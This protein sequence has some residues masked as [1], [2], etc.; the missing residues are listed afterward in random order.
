MRRI[1]LYLSLALLSIPAQGITITVEPGDQIADS[2]LSL[3]QGD[4]LFLMPG[5]YIDTT[6]QPL[7]TAGPVQ[8]GVTITSM[9]DNRAVLD[10]QGI[11]RSVINLT[12]PHDL[13]VI[14]ENLII[15]GGNATGSEA[16]NG[17]GISASESKAIIS[18]CLVTENTA[19]IGGGIGAEG[20]ILQIQY[21]T[22]SDNEA[23]VTGGGID[24]YACDFTGFMV[25]FLSNTSS[26][27]GGGINAYQ[28][29]L[30][31]SNSLF[32]GNCSGDDGGAIAV[33][34][35][36]S[37]FSFLTIHSNEAFDDGGGIRIHTVDSIS[38]TS[39]IVTSNLGKAGINVI[40]VNIPFISHVCCWDNTFSNYNG[41][42]DPTGTNGNISEDPLFADTDLNIS[43][44]AAGQ[45][46]DSPALNSGHA[47]VENTCIAGFSTRT[48]SLP[49]TGISDMGFHHINYEQTGISPE[50]PAER[51]GMTL[52]PS[53]AT[54]NVKVTVSP[55]ISAPV[56]IHV[57]D[58]T[59]RRIHTADSVNMTEKN[60]WI[61]NPDDSFPGGLV[62]FR[63]VWSDGSASG[64]VVL[65]R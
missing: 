23:L 7:L 38:I 57:Y 14:L 63:A 20:G 2:L 45:S 46:V 11:E 47:S 13:D 32:T 37:N 49:D 65:L 18:N 8:S 16:F 50:Q 21:S 43:Q 19:L 3:S 44:I 39:S 5:V 24:L 27:D 4:T 6:E 26:D 58:I 42:E 25:G 17:G 55:E 10:G 61:W 9:P 59:G 54:T 1:S 40:S 30:D 34:Q 12:G 53:P 29:T 41:M 36:T 48:D 52:T 60:S 33:L 56:V 64:R 31:L 62:L 22:V 28:S 15:T 51:V 35:G